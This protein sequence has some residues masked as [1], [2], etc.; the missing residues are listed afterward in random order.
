MANL[1]QTFG[2]VAVLI[3]TFGIWFLQFLGAV[4]LVVFSLT[5]LYGP[6]EI[7]KFVLASV[8]LPMFVFSCR[9]R[10]KHEWEYLVGTFMR[11]KNVWHIHSECIDICTMAYQSYDRTSPALVFTERLVDYMK[12]LSEEDI[13]VESGLK[14]RYT[15]DKNQLYEF[16]LRPENISQGKFTFSFTNSTSNYRILP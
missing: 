9:W 7:W 3:R 14:F 13:F 11:M 8:Y 12:H 2:V 4:A 16:S 10:L 15:N 5:D 6:H 1:E